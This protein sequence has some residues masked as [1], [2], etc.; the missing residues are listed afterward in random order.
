MLGWAVMV[1]MAFIFMMFFRKFFW[2][3]L[4]L[5]VVGSFDSSVLVLR[6]GIGCIEMFIVLLFWLMVVV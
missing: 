2:C 3:F 1:G 4:G 6:L 5:K